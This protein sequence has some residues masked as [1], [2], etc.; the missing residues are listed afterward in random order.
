MFLYKYLNEDGKLYVEATEAPETVHG[1]FYT[2]VEVETTEAQRVKMRDP[3]AKYN[4]LA[5]I[6]KDVKI[7]EGITENLKQIDY[8]QS[9]LRFHLD[10]HHPHLF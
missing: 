5:A 3:G 9:I 4:L 2:P 10:M 6:D 8:H 1:E 7:E